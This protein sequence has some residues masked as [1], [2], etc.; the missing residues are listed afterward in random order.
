MLRRVLAR[1]LSDRGFEVVAAADGLEAWEL[2]RNG[3]PPFD[4]VVTDMR[5]PRMD[6]AALATRVRA[7]P[8]H[9]PL[10]FISGYGQHDFTNFQPFL[11]KPF[12]PD[13][14]ARLVTQ[15]LNGGAPAVNRSL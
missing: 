11:C 10:I 12:H 4:V 2:L 6:G 3:G 13:E 15:V 8:G 9:P 7:V 1:G 5:M 14:L